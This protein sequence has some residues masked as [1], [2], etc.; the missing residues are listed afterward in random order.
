MSQVECFVLEPER[1][2]CWVAYRTSHIIRIH[3]HTFVACSVRL[4]CFS[5]TLI[6]LVYF[7][8]PEAETVLCF[9]ILVTLPHVISSGLDWTTFSKH[10]RR[11]SGIYTPFVH[12]RISKATLCQLRWYMADNLFLAIRTIVNLFS[13]RWIAMS[14]SALVFLTSERFQIKLRCCHNELVRVLVVYHS[15]CERA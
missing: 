6:A 8:V 11:L 4:R 10:S 13:E 3:I 12:V 1:L 2:P 5:V 15:Q 7:F 14:N 9:S